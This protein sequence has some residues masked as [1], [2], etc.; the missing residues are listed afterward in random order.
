MLLFANILF[1]FV[2]IFKNLFV[3]SRIFFIGQINNILCKCS[4][5]ARC[6]ESV[7]YYIVKGNKIGNRIIKNN[8]NIQSKFF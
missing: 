8:T 1:F 7:K 4:F 5:Y 2:M 3:I 6:C